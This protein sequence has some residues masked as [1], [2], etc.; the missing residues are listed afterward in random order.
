MQEDV[1]LRAATD[2]EFRRTSW[3]MD[4]I[5]RLDGIRPGDDRVRVAFHNAEGDIEFT[6]PALHVDGRIGISETVFGDAFSFLRDNVTAAVPKLTIP[7]PSMVHWRG[8]LAALDEAVYSDIDALL[9]RPHGCVPGGG[10]APRR[11]RLLVPPARRHEPRVSKRSRPA[12]VRGL[13]RRRSRAAARR[14]HP[15]RERGARRT[16]RGHGRDDAHVP[17]Q[18]PLLVGGGGR[19]RARRRGALPRARGRRVLHGVGRRAL[20]RLRAAPAPPAGQ[21]GRARTRDDEARR[22]RA[23]GRAEAA[24]RGGEPVRAGRAALPLAAVRLL[25]DR[26]GQR[27][28]ATTR[29]SRSCG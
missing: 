3:H 6:A 10:A 22:P 5:Y 1:G 28:H 23:E 24:D 2:G 17:R 29:R 15:P 14:V 16:A 20:R 9:E 26:R 18:L 25:L 12:G 7:S 8:G 27:A 19:L 21:A 13:D 11:A 4:F